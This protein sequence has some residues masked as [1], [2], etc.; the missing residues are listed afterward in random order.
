MC[1][2]PQRSRWPAH[3]VLIDRRVRQLRFAIYEMA[4]TPDVLDHSDRAGRGVPDDGALPPCAQPACDTPVDSVADSLDC[5]ASRA[6]RPVHANGCSRVADVSEMRAHDGTPSTN[7]VADDSHPPA[8][9]QT[10]SS[11]RV[12]VFASVPKKVMVACGQSQLR[13][14]TLDRDDL[15]P[16]LFERDGSETG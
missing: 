5:R 6:P 15:G 11:R 1:C 10:R 16:R 9:Q 13:E 4:S 12:L 3:N 2:G 7:T 14:G 8:R